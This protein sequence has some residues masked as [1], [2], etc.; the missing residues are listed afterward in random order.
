MRMAT[1]PDEDAGRLAAESLAV[2]DATGW[3]E[4]LYVAARNGAA[5]VPWDRDGPNRLLAEWAEAHSIAGGGRRALV[6]GAGLGADSE[7]VAGLGFDTVAFDVSATAI[8][9]IRGRYPQSAVEYLAAD[10][11]DPPG[12]WRAGFDLVV[13][14]LT[15]QSLPDSIRPAAIARVAEL[16]G[17]A[18]RWS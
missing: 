4:R 10:L 5:V 8:E 11:L 9:T 13:E 12:G 2:D 15:V 16:V 1:D 17:P 7:F 3:F 18:G 6:V 14:S